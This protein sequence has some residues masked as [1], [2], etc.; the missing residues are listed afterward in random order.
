MLQI[1]SCDQINTDYLV[2][3]HSSDPELL[4][5]LA[6][7]KHVLVRAR[8]AMNPY[9]PDE[10]LQLLSFDEE[11]IVVVEVASNQSTKPEVLLRLATNRMEGVRGAVAKNPSTPVSAIKSLACSKQLGVLKGVACN[12]YTPP[13][14][15][16][17]MVN[18]PE[19]AL[20]LIHLVAARPH[21]IPQHLYEL[22]AKDR[23]PSI[24]EL[25]ARNRSTP[26]SLRYAL[27]DDSN[28]RVREAARSVLAILSKDTIG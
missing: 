24:R 18:D 22:L 7:S 25:I 15:L 6:A 14:I 10:A 11:P 20:W 23:D 3:T 12:P 2:A 8:T 28:Q 9:S 4:L 13:E 27:S 19:K 17:D 1:K 16:T 21:G 26:L 5:K